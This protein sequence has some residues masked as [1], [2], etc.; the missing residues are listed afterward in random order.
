MIRLLSVLS[1]LTLAA[2][3]ETVTETEGTFVDGNDTYRS[4]TRTFQRSDGSTYQ[5][6]TIY[7][8]NGR[9]SC[10]ATDDLDCRGALLEHLLRDPFF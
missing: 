10:S 6:R 7:V 9:V 2:C 4:A 8:G 5:R 3:T 1:L